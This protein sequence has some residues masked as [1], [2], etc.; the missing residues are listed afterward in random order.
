RLPEVRFGVGGM[1]SVA[2]AEVLAALGMT[3][4]A[5]ETLEATDL[6]RVNLA[7]LAEPGFVVWVRGLLAQARLWTQLGETQRAI[8]AYDQVLR[9]WEGAD[10]IAAAE[11]RQARQELGRLRDAPR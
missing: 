8:A 3:R 2:R 10:G 6:R 5:V 11:V 7:G 9:W 4:Q 1:R